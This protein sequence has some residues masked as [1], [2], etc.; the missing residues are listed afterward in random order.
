MAH[1]PSTRSWILLATLVNIAVIALGFSLVRSEHQ[2]LR[3]ALARLSQGRAST[4]ATPATGCQAA[5]GD[6]VHVGGIGEIEIDDPDEYVQRQLLCNRRYEA[7][8]LDV[9]ERRARAGSTV[10][11]A[12]AFLGTHTVVMARTVGP[13]GRVIAFEPV[14]QLAERIERTARRNGFGNVEVVQKGVGAVAT[15]AVMSGAGRAGGR[16]CTDAEVAAG[17]AGCTKNLDTEHRFEII[18]IDSLDLADVSLIK[19]DVEGME[20]DVLR[21]ARATI[22]RERPVLVVEILEDERR[23]DTSVTRDDVIRAM[24]EMDYEVRTIDS[25]NFLGEPRG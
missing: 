24:R 8:V 22:A 16:A 3:E 25:R 21:G 19:I 15:T 11:D 10:I 14:V 1:D 7:E 20:L 2:E 23:S 12:G 4:A 17:E 6:V 5:P 18:P 13:T 9:I